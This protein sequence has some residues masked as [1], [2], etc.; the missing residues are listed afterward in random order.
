[1]K[2]ILVLVVTAAAGLAVWRK[3]GSGSKAPENQWAQATDT[4][5]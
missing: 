3:V 4:V 1:M 5:R 2:K